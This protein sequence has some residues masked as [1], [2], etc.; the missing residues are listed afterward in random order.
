VPLV[1]ISAGSCPTGSI[2]R[3]TPAISLA[4]SLTPAATGAAFWYRDLD[5]WQNHLRQVAD[6]HAY[7]RAMSTDLASTTLHA[8]AEWVLRLL[9]GFLAGFGAGYITHVALD[10]ATPRCLPFVC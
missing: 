5:D 9:S 8:L 10:F 7:G 1:E 2:R 4:H 3:S 6:Q